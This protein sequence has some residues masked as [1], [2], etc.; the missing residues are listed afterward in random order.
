MTVSVV[1]P[2]Y[3]QGRF[4]ERTIRSVLSQDVP[5]EYFVMDG[6]SRDE[7][8]EILRRYEA[9]L[10]WVSEK[11]RGQADAG[12]TSSATRGAQTTETVGGSQCENSGFGDRPDAQDLRPRPDHR[13]GG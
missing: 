6:G 10:Q 2:S 12:K 13:E 5:V 1:T 11:D 9:S 3:N 8:V 4:L 7:S